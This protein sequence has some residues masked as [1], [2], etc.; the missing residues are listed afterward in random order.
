MTDEIKKRIKMLGLKKEHVA[1][2]IGASP[3]ELSHFLNGKRG[4][5]PLKLTELKNYLNLR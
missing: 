3:S 5:D 1:K 2:R 4:I